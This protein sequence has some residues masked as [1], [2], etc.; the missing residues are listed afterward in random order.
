MIIKRISRAI[1]HGLWLFVAFKELSAQEIESIGRVDVVE[2]IVEV[3]RSDGTRIILTKGAD[4]YQNDTII[5]ST[6][7][8]IGITFV[9]DTIFSLGENGEMV[10]DELIYDNIQHAGKFSANIIMGVFSFISGEISKS[11]VDAM[12]IKTP[13]ATLGIR[14][15]KI[16]G[17]A[18]PEGSENTIS[19][20]PETDREGN[21]IVGELVVN[22]A[23]GTVVLNQVGA[24]V[25]MTSSFQP[26]PPPTISSQQE[27]QQSFG[28]TLTTL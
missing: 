13:V 10:I 25:K 22:N 14:G 16:V 7:S 3:I 15:T 5:T 17:K 21:T 1:K 23:A 9:D 4:V 12:T 19:L 27:I 6:G 26:P 24:T 11:S 2:G 18:A 20:L 8:S 28:E